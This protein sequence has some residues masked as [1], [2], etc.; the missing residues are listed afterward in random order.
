MSKPNPGAGRGPVGQAVRSARRARLR[1]AREGRERRRSRV[2]KAFWGNLERPED[3]A[4]REG[5]HPSTITKDIAV[6]REEYLREVQADRTRHIS[7]HVATL[8][9]WEA[10]A[11]EQYQ[12]AKGPAKAQWWDRRLAARDRLERALGLGKA[13]LMFISESKDTRYALILPD[14]KALESG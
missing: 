6:L 13:S 7:E 14:V 2:S 5:V 10:E 1:R 3:I 8:L 11:L 9:A 12:A 4:A